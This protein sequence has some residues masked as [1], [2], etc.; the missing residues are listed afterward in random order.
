MKCP[1]CGHPDPIEA[2][3]GRLL[4]V[5]PKTDH[6][7][8]GVVP[9]G[10]GGNHSSVAQPVYGPAVTGVCGHQFTA[11]ESAAA[12]EVRDEWQQQQQ[13]TAARAAHLASIPHPVQRYLATL[14]EH[15]R[16]RDSTTESGDA[17]L[18]THLPS[19]KPSVLDNPP[20]APD[21]ASYFAQA[22]IESCLPIDEEIAWPQPRTRRVLL[23]SRRTL[24]GHPLPT[25]EGPLIRAWRLPACLLYL[26]MHGSGSGQWQ[27]KQD[28]HIAIDGRLDTGWTFRTAQDVDP[29]PYRTINTA[30]SV[31]LAGRLGYP[32]RWDSKICSAPP[33]TPDD[34]LN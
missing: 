21:L 16:V 3:G 7:V 1:S 30:G 10:M 34:S 4:C 20:S 14:A 19:A 33:G 2:N 12:E 24:P 26:K 13:A 22:A 6:P 11:A 28:G 17:I 27:G 29:V 15:A 5:G 32:V 9:P 31:W 8:V 23:R 25:N 18:R